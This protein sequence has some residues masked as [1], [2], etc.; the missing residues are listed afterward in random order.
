MT[1]PV[2]VSAHALQRLTERANMKK[3]SIDT[4]KLFD[5]RKLTF[6]HKLSNDNRSIYDHL[7]DNGFTTRYIFN[8]DSSVLLTVIPKGKKV[9]KLHITEREEL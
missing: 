6:N 9:S 7:N 1:N 3:P 2:T 4:F 5:S 8:A